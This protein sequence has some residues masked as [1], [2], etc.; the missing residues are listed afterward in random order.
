MTD[1]NEILKSEAERKLNEKL[2]S[3]SDG[4]PELVKNKCSASEGAVGP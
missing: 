3:A 4:I 2:Q 1:N